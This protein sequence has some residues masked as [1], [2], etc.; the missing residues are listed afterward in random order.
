MDFPIM[1]FE[2][3]FGELCRFFPFILLF[4]TMG[5]SASGGEGLVIG[6]GHHTVGGVHCGG[7]GAGGGGRR[8]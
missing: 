6:E 7:Q 5:H 1:E 8:G 2:Y 3:I 4:V